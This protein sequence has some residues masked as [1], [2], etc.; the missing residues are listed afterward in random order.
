MHIPARKDAD[1]QGG[2]RSSLAVDVNRT[3]ELLGG[4]SSSPASEGAGEVSRLL[5]QSPIPG[6][7]AASRE[8]IVRAEDRPAR[9]VDRTDEASILSAWE[10]TRRAAVA[11]PARAISGP[12]VLGFGDDLDL[13]A[14]HERPHDSFAIERVIVR[15]D[16]RDAL[17]SLLGHGLGHGTPAAPR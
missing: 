2:G 12:S 3:G 13:A 8:A 5:A 6:C 16:D 1:M 7:P 9:S 4:M 11:A 15:H 10:R 14:R 17:S